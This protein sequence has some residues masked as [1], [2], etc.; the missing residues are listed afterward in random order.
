M[1]RAH[2]G[3]ATRAWRIARAGCAEGMAGVKQ[4]IA[5]MLHYDRIRMRVRDHIKRAHAIDAQNAIAQPASNGGYY[6]PQM[7]V[8][9]IKLISAGYA[10]MG[11]MS[12]RAKR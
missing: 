12:R 3:R 6:V 7:Y 4:K 9:K 10:V 1:Y 11:G 5:R 8:E 2:R